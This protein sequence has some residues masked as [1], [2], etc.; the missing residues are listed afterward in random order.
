MSD[1]LAIW[2]WCVTIVGRVRRVA[3]WHCGIVALESHSKIKGASLRDEIRSKRQALIGDEA[4]TRR[5][6]K[7]RSSGD[8]APHFS[9]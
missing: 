9:N 5:Q 7:R 6:P 2:R 4:S 1:A 8:E 3:L